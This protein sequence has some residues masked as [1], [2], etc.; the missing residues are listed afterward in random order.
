MLPD[1]MRC[2]ICYVAARDGRI[3][4]LK[5]CASY[6]RPNPVTATRVRIGDLLKR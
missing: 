4:H 5:T 2:I 1:W 6:V 3:T